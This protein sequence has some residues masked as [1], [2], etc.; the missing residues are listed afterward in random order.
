MSSSN[1]LRT[2]CSKRRNVGMKSFHIIFIIVSYCT[3]N[4]YKNFY[5]EIRLVWQVACFGSMKSWV[6]VPHLRHSS[7]CNVNLVDGLLWKREVVRSNRTT[8]T[9]LNMVRMGKLVSLPACKAG[10]SALWV[11]VP[12]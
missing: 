1:F 6:R 10:A 8:R 9:K 7:V 12:P 4:E 5:S 3:L 11:R 2:R